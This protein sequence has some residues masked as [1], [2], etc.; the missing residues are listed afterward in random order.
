MTGVQ[1]CA[2][3]SDLPALVAELREGP[4]GKAA[5]EP[6]VKVFLDALAVERAGPAGEAFAWLEL[7]L[8]LAGRSDG[9]AFLARWRPGGDGDLET[10]L[11]LRL[12]SAEL[13]RALVLVADALK[14]PVAKVRNVPAGAGQVCRTA[15]PAGREGL[16]WG[17][18]GN[19]LAVAGRV[20]EIGR[21][22]CRGRG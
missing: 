14:A 15:A 6:S 13:D 17:R 4:A 16:A 19:W 2:L 10:A 1:T 12:R 9:P 21:G 20:S 8:E 22:S 5:A 7:G 11:A 3:R 18:C